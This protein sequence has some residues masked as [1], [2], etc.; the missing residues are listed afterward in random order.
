MS[1]L[2]MEATRIAKDLGTGP[3][4]MRALKGVNLSLR[5]GELTLLMGPSGSGK[6]TLLSILG[7]MLTPTEGTVHVRGPRSPGIGAED[8]AKLR[9]DHVGFVFHSYHL[10]PTLTAADNVRLALDVRGEHA[11]TPSTKCDEA[12]AKVGF[13]QQD[14]I[15]SARAQR[16]RQQRVAIARAVVGDP[17]MILADE[18]TAALDS[19]NGKAIMT[20][21]GGNRQGFRAAAFWWSPTIRGWCRT[22]TGSS[23]SRTATSYGKNPAGRHGSL[24]LLWEGMNMSMRNA[25]MWSSRGSFWASL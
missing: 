23:I 16:R 5:G 12:L 10:F 19:E 9:R 6:T 25:V 8:L 18:P 7:C 4:Q 14:R 24:R 2:V 15:L 13:A 17:S 1:E 22:L 21:P 11:Q 20:H 3:A